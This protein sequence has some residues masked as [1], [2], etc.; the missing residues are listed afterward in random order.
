MN[1]YTFPYPVVYR[2]T[3]TLD[4]TSAWKFTLH[5]LTVL[6]L[7]QH[8][9]EPDHDKYLVRNANGREYE[10]PKDYVHTT[11]EEAILATARTQTAHRD[12]AKRNLE[13][14]IA[15]Y[16]SFVAFAKENGVHV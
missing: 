12:L 6:G 15:N 2:V 9:K 10:I 11:P 13:R 16:D 1:S 7:I 5:K 8:S 3:Y 14:A 4:L